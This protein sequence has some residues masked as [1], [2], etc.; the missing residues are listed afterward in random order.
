MAVASI[1][2]HLGSKWFRTELQLSLS[3]PI[4]HNVSGTLI[5]RTGCDLAN[6]MHKLI[7]KN[8][9][10]MKSVNV[11]IESLKEE[12]KLLKII[13]LKRLIQN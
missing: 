5:V 2:L 3:N 6:C 13:V 8:E 10:E 11:E 9:A 12:V 7:T 4:P 1:F